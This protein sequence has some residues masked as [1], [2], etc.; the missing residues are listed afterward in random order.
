MRENIGNNQVKFVIW[1][2]LKITM[3]KKKQR[4]KK[5]KR[6]LVEEYE[7]KKFTRY[8]INLLV[9]KCT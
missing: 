4:L 3:T 9:Y 1:C 7:E 8:D 5:Q 2:R 6:K